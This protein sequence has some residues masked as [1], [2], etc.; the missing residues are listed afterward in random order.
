MKRAL[1][2][3]VLLVAAVVVLWLA[4]PSVFR[5]DGDR[6]TRTERA[7]DTRAESAK[8]DAVPDAGPT[9]AED[10]LPPPVDLA[11]VDLDLDLHGVVVEKDGGEPVAGAELAVVTYPW[12]RTSVLNMVDYH[13]AIAGPSAH[14]PL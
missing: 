9:P 13:K 8:R 2:V 7:D 5:G 6:T 11:S 12:R 3:A 1:F 14:A 4:A 10:A